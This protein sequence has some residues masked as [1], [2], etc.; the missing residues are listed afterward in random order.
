MFSPEG[1]TPVSQVVDS[2]FEEIQDTKNWLKNLVEGS[3]SEVADCDP[4]LIE[5]RAFRARVY[6]FEEVKRM[7]LG[8]VIQE[9]SL[10]ACHPS[11]GVWKFDFPNFFDRFVTY[12]HLANYGEFLGDFFERGLD[13]PSYVT[14]IS[15][16]VED[17]QDP[18]AGTFCTL[19]RTSPDLF[20]NPHTYVIDLSELQLLQ[21][22]LQFEFELESHGYPFSVTELVPFEGWAL[23][24]KDPTEPVETLSIAFREKAARI[25]CD[26]AFGEEAVN[27]IFENQPEKWQKFLGIK[28]AQVL[29]GIKSTVAD[30]TKAYKFLIEYLDDKEK[31]ETKSELRQVCPIKLGERAFERV[32]DRLRQTYPELSRPGRRSK[33]Q[34]RFDTANNS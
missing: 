33:S 11:A 20:Y 15:N 29:S 34:R 18:W 19:S 3:W 13:W 27:E 16:C 1:Y 12:W 25:I 17:G 21:S 2:L 26:A 23:A 28:D 5:H 4:D 24:F 31:S 14:Q 30:E 22:T 10:Y 7:A 32:W 8:E 9:R 6:S